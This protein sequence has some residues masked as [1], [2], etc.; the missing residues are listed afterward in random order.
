MWFRIE[1]NKDGSVKSCVEVELS[2]SDGRRVAYVEADSKE[3]ALQ[4][5]AR[6]WV[7]R[8]EKS[9]SRG[10][11]RRRRYIAAGLCCYCGKE[12]ARGG[13]GCSECRERRKANAA[14]RRAGGPRLMSDRQSMTDGEKELK[15]LEGRRERS[16]KH[17]EGGLNPYWDGKLA[18]A[19]EALGHF[20]ATTPRSFR[21]WLKERIEELR[22]PRRKPTPVAAE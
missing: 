14:A 18:F 21:L 10:R 12:P 3:E 6:R 11:A 7:I 15:E 8:M 22:L 20:D 1:T 9:R 17:R 16:R 4:V 19:R 5:F 2:L 13:S